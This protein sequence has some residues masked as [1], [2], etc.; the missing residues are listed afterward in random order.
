MCLAAIEPG[1]DAHHVAVRL[2]LGERKVEQ[3]VSAL[4]GVRTH[5]V[6]GHVV[7]RTERRVEVERATAGQ[8][9]DLIER[10][11]RAPQHHR[12]PEVVHATPS[13][14][15]GQLRVLPRRQERVMVAGELRQLLDHHR[16][17]R[18]VDADRQRLGGEDHLHQTLHET[19][20]DHFLERRNHAGVVG[21]DSGLELTEERAVAEHREIGWID[22]AQPGVDDLANPIAF[23]ATGQPGTG[24][25]HRLGG[26]VALVATE[27]EVDRRQ[28][29][30]LFE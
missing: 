27:D 16:L 12:V 22:R 19:G 7:G 5:Q 11:E 24:S 15:T 10:H 17:G 2:I 28:H 13:G 6:R 29:P 3:V 18:H 8:R 14:A 1:L 23:G 26:L 25:H 20:L 4:A 9:G 21:R 30:V